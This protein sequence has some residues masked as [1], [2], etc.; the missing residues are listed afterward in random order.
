MQSLNEFLTQ[1]PH[2]A[3][4]PTMQLRRDALEAKE[5][6]TPKEQGELRLMRE[7]EAHENTYLAGYCPFEETLY[8]PLLSTPPPP[9][10]D[11]TPAIWFGPSPMAVKSINSRRWENEQLGRV[12]ANVGDVFEILTSK[13]Y[14]TDALCTYVLLRVNTPQRWIN[15]SL[16]YT[17]GESPMDMIRTYVQ[18]HGIDVVLP[19]TF[20]EAPETPI[21]WLQ[22]QPT[23]PGAPHTWDVS[24]IDVT[25]RGPKI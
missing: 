4:Q 21:A 6:L 7:R 24:H 11:G 14:F 15:F 19:E 20:V 16:L 10:A 23:P 17:L 22:L 5:D 25:T 13:A 9:R 12:A 1:A 3:L 2:D 18:Q 8:S